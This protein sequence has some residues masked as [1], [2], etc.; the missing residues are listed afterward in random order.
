[1]D[2][3]GKCVIVTGASSGIGLACARRFARL[4]ANVVNADLAPHDEREKLPEDQRIVWCE[5]DLSDE[6]AVR[7]LVPFCMSRSGAPDVLVNNA[8]YVGHKGG[9]L[10][11][12]SLEEWKHQLDVTLTGAFLLTSEVLA[13]MAERRE[14]AIVNV[15]SIG[16]IL[17]FASAAAYSIAKAALLQMTRSIA[18][19]YGQYGIRCNAVAPGPIDTPTFSSIKQDSFELRDR[20]CRTA[21]GRIGRPEEVASAV[22]FLAGDES[23]FITGAVLAVDGG[24]SASQWN[25]QLG[26]RKI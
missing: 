6:H 1:M 5:T 19:D 11:E 20:E 12:T 18:V 7:A 17:P 14:G 16:G 15:A 10:G 22:T 8:A 21:L 13:V 9:A 3:S 24:W 2:F 25:P 4:G 23:S 26:P